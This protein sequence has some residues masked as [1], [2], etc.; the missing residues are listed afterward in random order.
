MGRTKN[1]NFSPDALKRSRGLDKEAAY[2][3][4]ARKFG[5][6]PVNPK[7]LKSPVLSGI[8]D[9]NKVLVRQYGF[10]VPQGEGSREEMVGIQSE[11]EIDP[12]TGTLRQ[13][14][15]MPIQIRF[16]KDKEET[17]EAW[18]QMI[19][20]KTSD[21]PSI[22]AMPSNSAVEANLED[23][24]AFKQK[25]KDSVNSDAGK[26]LRNTKQYESKFNPDDI[27]TDDRFLK[28]KSDS[29]VTAYDP[30]KFK[31]WGV[32]NLSSEDLQKLTDFKEKLKQE[33]AAKREANKL[34][35]IVDDP[36]DTRTALDI[37]K[38]I[39][40]VPSD[41]KIKDKKDPMD[42]KYTRAV[43]KYKEDA[44]ALYELI[45]MIVENSKADGTPEDLD[46]L[47]DETIKDIKDKDID[48]D[49]SDDVAEMDGDM[50]LE[51]YQALDNMLGQKN[52]NSNIINAIS[53]RF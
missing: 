30:E 37:L 44:D 47:S 31:G 2:K 53:T 43:D 40:D 20:D 7:T 5:S 46:V 32:K 18:C 48:N 28:T 3:E 45:S 35:K 10:T 29:E 15:V 50:A 11:L 38:G 24:D 21:I 6:T 25:V 14:D 27:D 34:S 23:R 9:G 17:A 19:K 33:R 4:K 26:L 41:E 52:T 22:T 39:M 42:N 49:G 8:I 12:K 51:Y 36:E 13:T 1:S 16:N